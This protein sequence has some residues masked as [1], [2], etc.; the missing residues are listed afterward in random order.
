MN[1][2]IFSHKFVHK[3]AKEFHLQERGFKKQK[4]II[5]TNNRVTDAVAGQDQLFLK[6]S[7][8]PFSH[9]AG[10]TAKSDPHRKVTPVIIRRRKLTLFRRETTHLVENRPTCRKVAY[11]FKHIGQ[12]RSI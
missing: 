1:C 4:K 5:L 8:G 10:V 2:Q 12:W 11:L 7:E 6:M 9:D 3:A